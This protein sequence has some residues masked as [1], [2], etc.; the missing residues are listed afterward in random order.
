MLLFMVVTMAVSQ[1][2]CVLGFKH[3][4]VLV[5]EVLR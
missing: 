4:G 3:L 1:S 2:V 5:L